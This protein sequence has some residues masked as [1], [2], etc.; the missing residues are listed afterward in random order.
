MTVAADTLLADASPDQVRRRRVRVDAG[1]ELKNTPSPRIAAEVFWPADDRLTA[2]PLAFVCLPGGGMNR[3][4][5]DLGG[6]AQPSFS[7]ARRMAAAGMITVTIDHLGVG[8]STKPADGFELT[9]D[10]LVAANANAISLVAESLRQG[11]LIRGLQPLPSLATIG[12]GHS[13]GAMLTVMQQAIAPQHK[14]LVLLGFSNNGLVKY[15]PEAAQGLIGAPELVAENIGRIARQIHERPY[16]QLHPSAEGRTIFYSSAADQDGVAAL[17]AARD[18]LLAAPG[19]QSMI[20]GSI[21]PQSAKIDVPVFLGLGDQD[22]AGPTHAIPAAFP[23]SRDVSL[24]VLPETGHC[25]FIFPSRTALF[26][27]IRLWSELVRAA[28]Q[29]QPVPVEFRR[30]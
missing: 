28:D 27:R 19:L 7:F 6:S 24:L 26:E 2:P 23:G 25:Q 10:M 22:I 12:V 29:R 9:P 17:K 13:M 4:Y 5:F 1:V 30:G 11:T 18:V 16:Q 8:D 21:A 20:P 15:L 14:A 3:R